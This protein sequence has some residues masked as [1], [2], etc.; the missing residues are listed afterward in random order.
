MK[1]KRNASEPSWVLAVFRFSQS[2]NF[3]TKVLK[4]QHSVIFLFCSLQNGVISHLG[5]QRAPLSSTQDWVI[6]LYFLWSK[7]DHPSVFDYIFLWK[8][9][10][11]FDTEIVWENGIFQ[12]PRSQPTSFL[13]GENKERFRKPIFGY[14]R[15]LVFSTKVFWKIYLTQE[16]YKKYLFSSA[17]LTTII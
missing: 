8:T 11:T 9:T 12:N 1:T 4:T 16:K 7:N 13:L 2:E 5:N 15:V 6:W 17:V 10:A 14:S 3:L